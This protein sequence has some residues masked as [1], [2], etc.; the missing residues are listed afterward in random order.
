M[1]SQVY[2]VAL[3]ALFAQTAFAA[4]CSRTY[5]V[6]EGDFCDKISQS[7]NV[8]TYQLAAMN[9]N[10]INQ[11]CT[12]LQP[13]ET[14]CLGLS[15]EDC[16]TTYAVKPGDTCV[17]I[18]AATGLNMT[19]LRLNNPQLDE[20]CDIYSGEVLCISQTVQV[21]AIPSSGITVNVGGS[22]SSTVG[23]APSTTLS[24]HA[25]VVAPPPAGNGGQPAGQTT[26]TPSPA[27]TPAPSSTPAPPAPSSTP[28]PT[29]IPS[30]TPTPASNGDDDDQLPFCDEI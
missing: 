8:S 11:N 5:T 20:A 19:I 10:I 30:S 1:F 9:P 25:A 21:P 22:S 2:T 16:S 23:P 12:N 24:H 17:A 18:A 7:Q 28:T 6:A 14:I 26:P 29:P 13:G 15:G 3:L 27:S 4:T